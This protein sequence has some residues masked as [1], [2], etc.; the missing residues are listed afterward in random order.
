MHLVVTCF[1]SASIFAWYCF[2]AILFLTAA[3]DVR[4]AAT[5]SFRRASSASSMWG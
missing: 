4:S 1:R 2:D 5:L 3:R